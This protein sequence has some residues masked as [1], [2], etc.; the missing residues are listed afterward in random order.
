MSQ[1]DMQFW[2]M[3]SLIVI[4][5]SF[6]IMAGAVVFLAFKSS[7]AINTIDRFDE[8]LTPLLTQTAK[9]AVHGEEMLAQFTEVATHMA[10]A[11]QYFADSA[12][13]VKQEVGELKQLVGMTAIEAKQ[14]VELVSKTVDRT[15][16]QIITTADFIQDKVVTPAAEIAAIMAGVRK[17]LEVLFAPSPKQIDR[18]YQEDEMFI[19]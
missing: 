3:I 8:V 6:L 9:I 15:Q 17:G 4:A 7:K 5:V 16:T 12:G 11:S 10:T 14:K 18:V 19:G 13:L 2:M 1:Q